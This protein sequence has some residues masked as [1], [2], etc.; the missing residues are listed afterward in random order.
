MKLEPVPDKPETHLNVSDKRE[1]LE[2]TE[3]YQLLG[4][5]GISHFPAEIVPNGLGH[6]KKCFDDFRI[7]LPP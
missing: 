2:R 4:A 1:T 6:F 3:G 5:G 7:E